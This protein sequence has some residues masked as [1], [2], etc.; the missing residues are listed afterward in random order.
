MEFSQLLKERRSCRGYDKSPV[1]EEDLLLILEAAQ[2]A[3]SPLNLQPF[4]F[5]AVT[6][7]T[8]KSQIQRIGMEAKQAV[9]DNNG[10]GWAAKYPMGFIADCPLIVIV[11]YDPEKGGLG[12]YFN[13][14]HGALQSSSAA[15]QN[16]MLKAAELSMESLWFTFFDP[17]A[18]KPI[19]DIPATLDIAGAILIGK[20]AMQTKAPP[21]KPP[22]IHK[23]KFQP[24]AG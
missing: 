23:D 11:V 1:S 8:L 7:A 10:P 14:P 22:V 20:P 2:W 17:D 19:L 3:P 13:N 5:I 6:D 18:L 9:I 16:M 12:S 21:R 24:D 15:I 4:Q